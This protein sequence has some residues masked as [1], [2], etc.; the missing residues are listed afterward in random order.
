MGKLGRS[1]LRP[2]KAKH[3]PKFGSPW[4]GLKSGVYKGKPAYRQALG[5]SDFRA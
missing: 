5:D 3:R 4:A 1:M 2:S